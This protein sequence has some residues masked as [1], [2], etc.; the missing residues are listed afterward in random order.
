VYHGVADM[1][2]KQKELSEDTQSYTELKDTRCRGKKR[3][4]TKKRGGDEYVEDQ[5]SDNSDK[6]RC[7]SCAVKYVGS[8]RP[9]HGH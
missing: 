9:Y 1:T 5:G 6:T 2:S 8:G 3:V 4:G 7:N